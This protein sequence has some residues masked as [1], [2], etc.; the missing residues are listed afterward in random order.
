[1]ATTGPAGEPL[2]KKEH[3]IRIKGAG[4]I[5]TIGI[6]LSKNTFHFVGSDKPVSGSATG[7]YFGWRL[8][9]MT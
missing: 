2:R 9:E 1:M 3:A 4:N 5:T 8:I 7:D 6:D